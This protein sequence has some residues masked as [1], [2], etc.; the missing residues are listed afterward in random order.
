[1]MNEKRILNPVK[2]FL[3]I[4][5]LLFLLAAI[6][7]IFKLLEEKPASIP[8]TKI[9]NIEQTNIPKDDYKEVGNILYARINKTSS[10]NI[11][12]GAK[13]RDGSIHELYL[14]E[15]KIHY[16][17]FII[18]IEEA[19]QSYQIKYEWSD[20]DKSVKSGEYKTMVYCVQ[21]KDKIYQDSECTDE[22]IN[23]RDIIVLDVIRRLKT[24]NG[25]NLSIT[26][27]PSKQNPDQKITFSIFSDEKNKEYNIQTI[28]NFISNLGES[29]NPED[30]EYTI[31]L[32]QKIN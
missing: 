14:E 5:E 30:Y 21:K 32:S 18:D 11:T 15:I 6:I 10:K 4:L 29:F 17:N 16:V 3:F 8:E 24:I 26:K 23:P 22:Y 1:M 9:S 28:K 31:Q 20:N 27:Q 2:I 7:T 25:I 13:I 19:R 12:S